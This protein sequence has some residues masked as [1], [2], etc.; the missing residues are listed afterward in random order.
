MVDQRWRNLCGTISCY[1]N[2]NVYNFACITLNINIQHPGDMVMV[3]ERSNKIVAYKVYSRTY[4]KCK[5]HHN[6]PHS[7]KCYRNFEG[8]AKAMEPVITTVIKLAYA[9]VIIPIIKLASTRV[10]IELSHSLRSCD[11]Y[12]NYTLKSV[13]PTCMI[14]SNVQFIVRW[15]ILYSYSYSQVFCWL[16]LLCTFWPWKRVTSEMP[17][18]G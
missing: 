10:I 16:R 6:Q 12:C 7:G 2:W 13:I 8:S 11:N 4:S 14:Y 3:G 15:N 17:F 5:Q 1:T 18:F 9:R